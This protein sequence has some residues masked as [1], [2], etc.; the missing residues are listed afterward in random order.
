MATAVVALGAA[1]LVAGLD[2]RFAS[3]ITSHDSN[4][5]DPLHYRVPIARRVTDGI[6]AALAGE[7]SEA[8]AAWRVLRPPVPLVSGST[9]P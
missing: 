4:F 1:E 9:G 3:P 6:A 7:R 8:S 2:R 5:W